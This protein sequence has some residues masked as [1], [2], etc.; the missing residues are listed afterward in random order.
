MVG[1]WPRPS[2]LLGELEKKSDGKITYEDFSRRADEAVLLSLKQ[3][4]D[5]GLDVVTDGEQRRDSFYSF[6]ADKVDGIK[7]ITVSELIDYVEDKA[8]YERI[9]RTLDVP[10]F[11]I[12]SPVAVG[13]I[14]KRKPLAADELSFLRGHTKRPIKV[15]LPGP[16]MLTRASWVEPLSREAYRTRDE[17]AAA[18]VRLLREEII[19][20]R[21]AGASFVQLDEPTLTEVVY[22]GA[23]AGTFMCAAILSKVEP[24][25]E[26]TFATDLINQVAKGITGVKLGVHVCR[27]NW[28]RTDDSLLTGDYSPL[29]PYFQEMKVDQL[30]LEFA[31]ERAGSLSVF[32]GAADGKEIG[33]G[34]VNPRSDRVESTEEIV[35]K[36]REAT[37]YFD[38][39]RIYLNPDCGFATFAEVPLNPAETAKGKLSSMAKAAVELRREYA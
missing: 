6:V 18:Y 10:A 20:L 33:L 8:M 38:P 25:E 3:Q 31:T 22:G 36:A 23:N 19:Q 2:W 7:L 21:D 34:V 1:S 32:D 37:K 14:K 27:G 16:F 39:S 30:V 13:Q 17:L 29:I 24:K 26:L 12:K 9:L 4:E 5:A 28:S 11:A 35:A 15:P